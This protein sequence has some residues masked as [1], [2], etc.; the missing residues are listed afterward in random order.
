MLVA[1]NMLKRT[2]KKAVFVF[3]IIRLLA[4]DPESFFFVQNTRSFVK[5]GSNY[6]AGPVISG[7]KCVALERRFSGLIF[8]QA[9]SGVPIL[10][11]LYRFKRRLSQSIHV[12]WFLRT[13]AK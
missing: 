9:I 12:A 6:S 8:A 2:Q 10:C 3:Q 4:S 11:P 7:V 5:V 1:T 13:A